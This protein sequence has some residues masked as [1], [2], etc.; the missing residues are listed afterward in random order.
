MTRVRTASSETEQKAVIGVLS[1]AFST[2]PM[3][4]WAQP[5]PQKYIENFPTLARA[6]G[7][8]S[9]ANGTAY[10]ADGFAG[11]AMWLPPG[12]GPDEETLIGLVSSTAPEDIKSHL[13]GVFEKMAEF[14]PKEPHWYLPMIGVDPVMQGKGLGSALM[15]HGVES[16][17]RDRSIAYLESSNPRNVPLYERYGFEVMGEIQV[18]TS[19]V[20]YPML[21]KP[22]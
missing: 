18:G 19:P 12:I 13:F 15:A 8:N 7:G 5:D 21:R 10:L 6:F 9:F 11:A 20:M 3:A 16:C 14:H 22:H 17:D 2:D 4:R 1:L